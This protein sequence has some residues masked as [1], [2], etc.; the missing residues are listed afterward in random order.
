[1]KIITTTTP[2]NRPRLAYD[3][4]DAVGM[5]DVP[6]A[7]MEAYAGEVESVNGRI[8]ALNAR[9]RVADLKSQMVELHTLQP[10]LSARYMV[11]GWLDRGA[12]SVVYGE[13][14]VGK[15]FFALDLSL[16]VAAGEDWYGN[17]ISGGGVVYVAG[18][19]GSGINNRI[20]AFRR[21]RPDLTKN[22]FGRNFILMKTAID[23]CG[24]T[25]AAAICDALNDD[26]VSPDLIVIDT[27][28]MAFGSGDENTAKDMGL[29][30]QNCRFIRTMTGAHVMVI[31]H[32]GKDTSKGARGSGSLRATSDTEIELTRDGAVI[33]TTQREQRDMPI[34]EPFAYTL[35]TVF[36]GSDEDGDP[37]TSAVVVLT[38]APAK[39]APQL[40]GQA[41]IALRAF[42]DA[43]AAHG[44]MK[45]G[46]DF[47]ANRQCVSLDDWRKACD[48]HCLS[49]GQG[50]SSKRAAV[51]KTRKDL[52]KKQI[53]RVIDGFAW[54]CEE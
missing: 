38:E 39:R 8:I 41:L 15:T 21:D 18:E 54:R 43:L 1:M 45:A 44:V 29:F 10:F 35:R 48:R 26:S 50:E 9:D 46:G 23:L 49:N 36:I 3:R 5:N 32:S 34:G 40:K 24:S 53:V 47:P 25:D 42:D 11:K 19:G 30:V 16:H 4:T 51:H 37:V 31:H 2:A 6:F 27:L 14:N 17:R 28:A 20:E 7:P 12:L 13:S 52:Q 22:L 33:I